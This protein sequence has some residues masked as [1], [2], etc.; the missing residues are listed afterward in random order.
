MIKGPTLVQHEDSAPVIARRFFSLPTPARIQDCVE[1]RDAVLLEQ[2]EVC[3]VG[4][5]HALLD[6]RVNQVAHQSFAILG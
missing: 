6:G 3:R 2:N 4:D 5:E 1:E